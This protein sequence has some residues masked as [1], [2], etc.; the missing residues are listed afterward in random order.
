MSLL[1][2]EI[3]N[4]TGYGY[5]YG[6]AYLTEFMIRFSLADSHQAPGCVEREWGLFEV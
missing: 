6:Y 5:G 2:N 1:D 4:L 3:C